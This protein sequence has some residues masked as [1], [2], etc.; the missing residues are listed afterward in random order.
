MGLLDRIFKRGNPTDELFAA[1]AASDAAS[2]K[3]LLARGADSR[4][5]EPSEQQ[6]LLHVAIRRNW[7]PS[8][9]MG[10]IPVRTRAS[11]GDVIETVGL[12]LEAGAQAGASDTDGITPLHW[13]AG[14][15][16][17]N[18]CRVLLD[19]GADVNA[20]DLSSYTPLHQAT[21]SGHLEA[22]RVLIEAGAD[23]NVRSTH[24]E[25]PLTFAEQN[26]AVSSD[27]SDPNEP[28]RQLLRQHG[29][30]V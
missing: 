12:L 30:V 15:G 2:V 5:R 21:S 20:C 8:G 13:A 27:G 3:R 7:A 23:V 26:K 18:V 10:G 4:A 11:L 6:T 22:A 9:E 14:H 24:G 19:A 28:I 1:A 16:M 17:A 29:G 25:T